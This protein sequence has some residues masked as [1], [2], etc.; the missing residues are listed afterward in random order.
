MNLKAAIERSNLIA[1]I[2][3]QDDLVEVLQQQIV[4]SAHGAH[5]AVVALH[6]FFNS[7]A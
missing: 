3:A 7:K 6:E 1:L 2:A 5:G 4:E